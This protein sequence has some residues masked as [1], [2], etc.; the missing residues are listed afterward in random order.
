MKPDTFLG[1]GCSATTE[2]NTGIVGMIPEEDFK[3]TSVLLAKV[4]LLQWRHINTRTRS[5]QSS[6]VAA[7]TAE[8]WNFEKLF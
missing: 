1:I 6:I 8:I 4:D 3:R 2:N 5:P 7:R